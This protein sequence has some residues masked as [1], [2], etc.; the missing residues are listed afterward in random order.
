MVCNKL[1]YE[2]YRNLIYGLTVNI[3]KKQKSF[4]YN[5]VYRYFD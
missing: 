2:N 5:N 3:I 1:K 4:K